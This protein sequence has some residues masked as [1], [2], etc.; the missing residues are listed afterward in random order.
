MFINYKELSDM[1]L[2]IT[3]NQFLIIRNVLSH[4]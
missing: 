4:L 3:K 2:I 1:L